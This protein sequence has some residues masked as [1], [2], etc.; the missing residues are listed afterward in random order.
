MFLLRQQMAM[1]L[2]SLSLSLTLLQSHTGNKTHNHKGN[3]SNALIYMYAKCGLLG[4]SK[5]VLL[6]ESVPPCGEVGSKVDSRVG[7]LKLG[8]K[9]R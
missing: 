8:K 3:V 5:E 7:W 2:H 1:E 6:C 9:P 4:K